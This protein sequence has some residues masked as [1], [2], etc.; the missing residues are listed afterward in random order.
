MQTRNALRSAPTLLL[1]VCLLLCLP[2]CARP[3][4]ADDLRADV[5][6]LVEASY[7][8]N[9]VF[10]GAGLPVLDRQHLRYC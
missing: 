6:A 3:P 8:I 1:V 5:V 4:K 7:E 9:E 2:S 10:L